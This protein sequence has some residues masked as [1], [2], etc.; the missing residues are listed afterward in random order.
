M[1]CEVCGRPI[2]HKTLLRGGDRK[3][4]LNHVRVV[5]DYYGCDTGCCGHSL[6]GY[7]CHG[8]EVYEKFEFD[9]PNG[10]DYDEFARR[11]VSSILGEHHGVTILFG[12]C[13]VNDKC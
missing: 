2:L 12:Q 3:Y 10:E 11:F 1:D 8:K 9:H 6:I 4:H 7:D 5:H 13:E